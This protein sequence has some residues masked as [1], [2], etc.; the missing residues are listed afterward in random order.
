MEYS[1]LKKVVL[2]YN[3]HA[4]LELLERAFE[5][6][7]EAHKGKK[8]ESGEDYMVHLFAVAMKLAE[9]HMDSVTIAAGL[10]HDVLEDTQ[11]KPE[12]LVDLFG[13]EVFNLVQGVTK[14]TSV[15]IA[16]SDEQRASNIRNV[17]LATAKDI[18]VIIIKLAD[19][20][21][22]MQTLKFL[23]LD[24]QR[25]I[26]Q[27]SLDVYAPIAYKLGMYKIKAELEDLAFRYLEPG[28]YQE[29]KV[30]IGKKL[31]DRQIEVEHFIK[32]LEDELRR[33]KVPARVFEIG[34]AHV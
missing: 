18:R 28:L 22:N 8:R 25:V 32:V 16:S 14:T 13:S 15:N 3:P 5:F 10:L 21:H 23:S 24:R 26:A 12:R 19:R 30:R 2:E 11:T 9:L 7:K 34:R 33:L 4:N 17:L 27:E 31:S 6:A 1:D 20:L 29:F